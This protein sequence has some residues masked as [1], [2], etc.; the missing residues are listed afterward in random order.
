MKCLLLT[1][2]ES[3]ILKGGGIIL[4]LIHHLFYCPP[5]DDLYDDLYIYGHGVINQIGAFSKLCVAIF[6]F[7]SGYGLSISNDRILDLWRF[8]KNRFKKL[9]FNYWFI[10][11]IFVPIG[12]FLFHRTF[13]DVY[14]NNIIV[15][16][17]LDF[18]GVLNLTGELG[19][20]PTWWFY[21]CII[22]LYLLFPLLNKHI[23]RYPILILI[24][25]LIISR[26]STVKFVAPIA[27]YLLPFV[28][29]VY[30]AKQSSKS[31]K[32]ISIRS[33]VIS[34]V[35]LCLF[36][37]I[38]GAFV[39]IIDTLICICL[40]L[41]VQKYKFANTFRY[42]LIN[43]G[44]HST[45]IFLF[46]T[47]IYYYWFP[48]IIYITRNPIIILFELIIVCYSISLFIEFIKRKI[49]FFRM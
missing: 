45:N 6:V 20:N 18:L 24:F 14:L 46:H 15:K 10:W 12:V 2:D 1:K 9:Y 23:L 31:F 44:N 40:S 16:V 29:G 21:A 49:G 13:A 26:F 11:L 8:Y 19:Y 39:F 41:F 28:A 42:S 30:I 32:A 27:N 35:A 7:V 37:N 3:L 17:I 47:F 36:R 25:T 5:A 38:A 43:L 48:D 22:V 33:I 34:L 4:M